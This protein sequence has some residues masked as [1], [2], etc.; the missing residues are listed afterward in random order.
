[1]V[2]TCE[3]LAPCAVRMVLDAH[4]FAAM[5]WYTTA[6]LNVASATA[7]GERVD[8]EFVSPAYLEIVGVTPML[9]RPLPASG[10]A[11][12][13]ADEVLISHGLWQRL[14][15]GSQ[16]AVG[17]V[18]RVSGHPLSIVGVLPEGYRGLSGRADLW[19]PDARARRSASRT[20]SARAN[21]F[22]MSSRACGTM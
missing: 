17:S 6:A 18:V 8:V 10:A 3:P 2:A 9:G 15:G 12:A 11:A 19:I 4:S 20:T 21:I 13:A 22:T 14:F 1:M 16:D 5:A 7:G